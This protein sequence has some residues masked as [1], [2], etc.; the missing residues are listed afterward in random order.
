MPAFSSTAS[1]ESSIPVYGNP[2]QP[3]FLKKKDYAF[4][5]RP[6]PSDD[7]VA[8]WADAPKY[9]SV[10]IW[11]THG[12][13]LGRLDWIPIP[14]LKGCAV[15]ARAVSRAKPALIVFGHYHISHGAE[16]V[17]WKKDSDE[18]E[19][20]ERLV[21]D[22]KPSLLDFTSN[23]SRFER[24]EKTVFVNAAWMTLNKSKPERYQ[25]IVL[26]LPKQLLVGEA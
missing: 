18:A 14:P 2:R 23:H 3:D 22:G 11:V 19:Q 5:Y 7:S 26:D 6:S 4:T 15:Q 25:P 10:P 17:T 13:P 12:P 1:D 8:A 9:P 16:V 21:E 20:V 24:G